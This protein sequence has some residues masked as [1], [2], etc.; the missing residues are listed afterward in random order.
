MRTKKEKILKH[1]N[2][3]DPKLEN[4]VQ[5][6]DYE[7]WFEDKNTGDSDLFKSLCRT[8]VGQ[9]LAGAAANAIYGRFEKLLSDQITP[10][11]ILS[12]E[13]E[14]IRKAGLSW[15]KVRSVTDLSNKIYVGEIV[16]DN[17]PKLENQELIEKLVTVK[18]IG[19]WTAEMFL[20]F[21][22]GKEDI[23]SWGDLGLRKGLIK[24]LEPENLTKELMEHRVSS[25]SPY[26]TYGAIAMWHLLDN[27]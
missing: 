5:E 20:M 7:K 8:I 10:N 13:P 12:I 3:A 6:I 23:F 27:R 19:E 9:Q 4:I 1:F 16:L 22:M 18:G 21:K 24:F 14:K 2:K 17:L 15:A 26:K 25:W 11:N